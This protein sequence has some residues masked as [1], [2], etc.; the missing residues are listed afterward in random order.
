MI[1]DWHML[2]RIAMDPISKRLGEDGVLVPP[3][4][5]PKDMVQLVED[6]V[7]NNCKV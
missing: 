4:S 2:T 6:H 7:V 3:G 5:F 1:R